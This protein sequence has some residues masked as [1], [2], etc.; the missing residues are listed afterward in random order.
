N[1]I[2]PDPF[3]RIG[4]FPEEVYED[5]IVKFTSNVFSYGKFA[6]ESRFMWNWG[7]G[8]YSYQKETSHAWSEAGVY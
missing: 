5:E 3:A 6:N 8:Y 4:N 7:D 1:I 2:N